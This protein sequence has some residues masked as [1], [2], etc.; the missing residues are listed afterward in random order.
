[1]PISNGAPILKGTG[2]GRFSTKPAF[3]DVARNQRA[4]AKERF[5]GSK[6]NGQ[7]I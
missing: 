3:R 7:R 4:P 5:N 6:E 1:M 2:R